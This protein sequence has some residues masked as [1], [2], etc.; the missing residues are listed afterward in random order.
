[1]NDISLLIGNGFNRLEDSD[2]PNWDALI[3]TPV[4]DNERYVDIKNMSYPLKFEYIVN[5]YN[6]NLNKHSI[7]SYIEIK[8]QISE[9]LN[10]SIL[11]SDKKLD[12][13]ISN[14]LLKIAP[15]N[16]L[17]TNYDYLLEKV[18][19]SKGTKAEYSEHF[20]EIYKNREYFLNRTRRLGRKNKTNF[21]H[22]HGI[23]VVPSSVCLGYEHYMRIVNVLRKRIIGNGGNIRIIEYLKNKA[24]YGK[25]F[26]NEYETK[27]F[28]TDMYIIGLGLTSEEIDLW[29]I[30]CYRAYLY[31]ADVDGSKKLINNKI[32]YLDVHPTKITNEGYSYE[33]DYRKQQYEMFRYM[34][35]DY[36]P[37]EVSDNGFKGKY[38][39]ALNYIQ[40]NRLQSI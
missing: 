11:K 10:Q 24:K 27:F 2:F 25:E 21:Y 20:Q 6:E 12:K 18:F 15:S 8:K 34:K 31:Y 30:L 16:I 40:E 33:D 7:N 4:K 36:V 19:I 32:V 29:W 5:F 26:P 35:I 14:L 13:E 9:R 37:F 39:E 1:M 38:I 28:D 22:V 23:D 3:R 17:T